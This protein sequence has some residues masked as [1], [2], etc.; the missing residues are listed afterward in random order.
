[1]DV[2]LHID[3]LVLDGYSMTPAQRRTFQSA[4][5][6]ELTLL[7]SKGGLSDAA[8][9]GFRV[10]SLDGAVIHPPS[11]F[12]PVS[13]GREVARALYAGIGRRER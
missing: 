13:L 7:I 1:M 11:P 9:A 4:A 2:R 8:A 3:R 12:H 10:P 5:E 6:S